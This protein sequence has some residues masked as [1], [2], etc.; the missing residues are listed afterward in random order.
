MMTDRRSLHSTQPMTTMRK[1]VPIAQP[2]SSLAAAV[3]A[4]ALTAVGT[5]GLAGLPTPSYAKEASDNGDTHAQFSAERLARIKPAMQQLIDQ[6]VFPG[7][8]T[9]V[10]HQGKVVLFESVGFLDDA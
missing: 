5:A 1:A 3:L 6:K 8:V 10:S 4:A 7:A 9:L 2:R